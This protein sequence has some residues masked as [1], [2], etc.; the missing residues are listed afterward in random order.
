MAREKL[1]EEHKKNI[2]RAMKGKNPKNLLLLIEKAKATR[3]KKGFSPWNKGRNMEDYPQMG[4][5]KG[6][7]GYSKGNPI[8]KKCLICRKE[9]RTYNAKLKEGKGKFCSK[10]CYF[11]NVRRE[12]RPKSRGENNHNWRGGA[13]LGTHGGWRY[14]KWKKEIYERD[15]YT[16]QACGK[17]DKLETHHLRSWVKYPELRYEL[18]NGTTLCEKC[19]RK[20]DRKKVVIYT[21]RF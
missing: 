6:N 8:F 4:F 19:H 16:C 12:G 11:E 5:Q 7:C 10:K 1:S 14:K 18:S 3:F 2:S 17:K 21:K 20:A 13:S 9:F 15:N